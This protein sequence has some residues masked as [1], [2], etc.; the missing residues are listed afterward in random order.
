VKRRE[1]INGIRVTDHLGLVW[2]VVNRYRHGLGTLERDDLFQA[3]AI[4]LMR[5][6]ELFDHTR[7]LS[8]STWCTYY[9][10]GAVWRTFQNDGR[11]VRIPVH[12]QDSKAP[13]PGPALSLDDPGGSWPDGMASEEPGAEQRAIEAQR[14]RRV[15]RAMARLPQR[16]RDVLHGHVTE[17]RTLV[18]VAQRLQRADGIMGV[19]PERARQLYAMALRRLSIE[20]DATLSPTT[21][22][23]TPV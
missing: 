10:R 8:V 5:G 21:T 19:S 2:S 3:G 18:E 13:L 15:R 23:L 6:L 17:E 7:G 9:I 12:V 4:G 11:V 20:L 16:D 14:G 1:V 22:D